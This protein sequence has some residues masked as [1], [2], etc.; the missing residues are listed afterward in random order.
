MAVYLTGQTGKT[1]HVFP[2]NI[3]ILK[4]TNAT[5]V[6]STLHAKL[7]IMYTKHQ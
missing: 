6:L 3:F 1:R 5:A 7:N 2:F 4:E